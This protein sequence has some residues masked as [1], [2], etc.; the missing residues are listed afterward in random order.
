MADNSTGPEPGYLRPRGLYWRSVSALL[1]FLAVC[2]GLAAVLAY[3]IISPELAKDYFSAH[4][5]VKATWQLV[6]PALAVSAG[7][8]F[9]LTG[10]GVALSVRSHSRRVLEPLRQLDGLVRAVGSGKLPSAAGAAKSEVQAGAVAAFEPLAARERDLLRIAREIQ[11]LSLELNYRS[12]G[13]AEVTL[14]DLRV[15]SARLDELTRDLSRT[16]AWFEG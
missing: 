15:L 11:K 7:I 14:K 8:G 9:L 5:T 4:R 10:V 16:S 13:T 2:W 12:A 1:V 6:V 3:L